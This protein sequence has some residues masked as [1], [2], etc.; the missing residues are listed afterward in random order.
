MRLR[1]WD[2]N[3]KIRLFG[4]GLLNI[5]FWMFFPFLA[6]YFSDAFGKGL[7]G[8]LLVVS[9]VFGVLTN[10]IGGWCADR[11]GR[12]RMMLIAAIGEGICFLLFAYANSPWLESP[13]LSF[14]CFA[15]LGITGTLYWPASHAMIADLVGPKERN[16]V[17]AAFYTAHNLAVVIGPIIG[18]FFFFNHRF[19][20]L[21][22]AGG[23]AFLLAFLIAYALRETVP[24]H[25]EKPSTNSRELGWKNVIV[26]QLKDYRVIAQDRNFL[27]FVVAGI[28][29]AQTFMQLDLVVAVY[30]TKAIPVQELFS[31]GIW[32]IKT[33]GAQFFGWLV[34]LNGF[35]VVMLTVWINRWVTR[36][37]VGNVFI[38]SALLYGISMV[39]LGSSTA[40]WVAIGAIVILTIA[41]LVG[42]GLQESF[43]SELA[44]EHMRGQYFAAASLRF[45]IGRTFAPLAIPL[46][47]WVGYTWMFVVLA[48]I[49]CMGAWLYHLLFR[50]LERGKLLPTKPQV[51]NEVLK[52]A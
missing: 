14:I 52:Q 23:A 49:A 24:L 17:F 48:G 19:G 30:V 5:L 37:R 46:A 41:E 43:V 44:P 29:I 47:A 36:F 12:R 15:A 3:L 34:A 27:L 1:N 39:L 7:A 20:L 2:R 50:R 45:T 32:H 13:V 25:E 31:F 4:E 21:L 10:L 26:D 35:L 28:L 38:A 8:I 40:L 9:N 18:G 11:F 6:V 33:G 42:V 51:T 22:A 16:E